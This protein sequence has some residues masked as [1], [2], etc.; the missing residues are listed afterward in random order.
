MTL[1]WAGMRVTLWF[2][3]SAA[4][5]FTMPKRLAGFRSSNLEIRSCSRQV[6][7]QG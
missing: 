7:V 5:P 2:L 4:R 3:M 1:G 6:R